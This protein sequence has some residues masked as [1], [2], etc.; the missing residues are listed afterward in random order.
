MVHRSARGIGRAR[1]SVER[2]P[3]VRDAERGE[4]RGELIELRDALDRSQ[5]H[6]V[7]SVAQFD[8]LAAQLAALGI[9]DAR[10]ALE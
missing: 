7:E 5:A 4:L 8:E 2:E 6:P 3:R 9:A 1:V 10:L